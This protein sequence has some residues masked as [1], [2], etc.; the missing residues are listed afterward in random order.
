MNQFRPGCRGKQATRILHDVLGSFWIRLAATFAL[1]AV[2]GSRLDLE[3]IYHTIEGFDKSA[4]LAMFGVNII[5]ILAFAKR[6][7]VIAASLDFE[8]PYI[9]VVRAIWLATFLGQ[10]GPTLVIAEATRYRMLKQHATAPQLILSQ[11]LD[12]LSGQIV[13]F[14]LV[15]LLFPCYF[16]QID[17]S[18]LKLLEILFGAMLLLISI[19]HFLNR[20]IRSLP[21]SDRAI[22]LLGRRGLFGHYSLSLIIQLLLVLNFCLAAIGLGVRDQLLPLLVMAPLL[23]AAITFLPITL[24]DWGSRETAAVI[25]LSPSGLDSETIVSVSVLYGLFHLLAALPGGL[26]LMRNPLRKT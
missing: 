11:V 17:A 26:F 3:K 12:R 10:F 9:Q 20:R 25:L 22:E 23:F 14:I 24:A 1:I 8:P 4:G 5:L 2:L 7:Q 16:A 6:W 18:L 19:L 13:L 15:L 21:H